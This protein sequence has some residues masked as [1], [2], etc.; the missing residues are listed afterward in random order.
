M[1][2]G[3]T[4]DEAA[5]KK[6]AEAEAK[7]LEDKKAAAKKAKATLGVVNDDP[8]K[9]MVAAK[10]LY[11]K[12]LRA[13]TDLLAFIETDDSWIWARGPLSSPLI[14]AIDAIQKIRNSSALWKGWTMETDFPKWIKKN[15]YDANLQA[16][17]TT[18]LPQFQKLLDKIIGCVGSLKRMHS[19]STQMGSPVKE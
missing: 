17:V 12:N 2:G 6:A 13:A 16:L 7:A 1:R 10:V 9:K 18:E 5:A 8:V 4:A 15:H 11:D 3:D 14:T 19:S